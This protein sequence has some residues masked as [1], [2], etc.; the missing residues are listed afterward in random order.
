MI[1]FLRVDVV[2]CSPDA[3]GEHFVA[4]VGE[5]SQPHIDRVTGVGYIDV[6]IGTLFHPSQTC[7]PIRDQCCY[8]II[9]EY[10]PV[11]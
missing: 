1:T 6:V 4:G 2:A 7:Q 5:G 10:L 11:K 8:P 9:S 3:E